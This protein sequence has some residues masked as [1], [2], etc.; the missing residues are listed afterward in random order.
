MAVSGNIFHSYGDAS[1]KEDV[2]GLIEYLTAKESSI[3]N[4]LPK[5][6]A[7]DTIHS[8][9]TDT[10][11]TAATAAVAEDTDYTSATRTAPS[12]VTNVIEN[13]AIPFQV[14][15][16]QQLI[17]HYQGENELARQTAKAM[18]DWHNAVE[19]D[20]VHSTL[21]SGQSGATPKMSGLLEGISQSTNYT[22]HSSG[23]AWSASVLKGLQAEN[24]NRNNG[25]V[26]T[27]LFLGK[28]LKDKTD[29]FTNKSTN[30]VTGT[31]VKEVVLAVDVFETGFGKLKVHAHRYVQLTSDA[32]SRVL[33]INPDKLGIA[34][35]ER[36][37]IDTGLARS[38]DYDMRAVIGKLTLEFKNKLSNYHATGFLLT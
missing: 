23:T 28:V 14:T 8:T 11:R 21:T 12:R 34:F 37:R 1:R 33:A 10:Y 19:Y 6:D 20:I 30:V 17:D 9:L 24:W 38:G 13:V 27:D 29:D 35:L 18:V 4:M 5:G 36:P 22:A 2:L 25:D 32:T 7:K 3:F 26:A 16:T 31:N 15:R